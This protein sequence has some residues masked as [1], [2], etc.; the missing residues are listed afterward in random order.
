MPLKIASAAPTISK[1]Y[2]LS[3]ILN[4]TKQY[5]VEYTKGSD[6]YQMWIEDTDSIRA[7]IDLIN[8]YELA[9]SAFWEKDRENED[10]WNL[11]QEK[12]K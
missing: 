2:S 9:G 1:Q 7:K 4:T 10:I 11:V 12:L 8:Q 5:Y 6:K 3:E